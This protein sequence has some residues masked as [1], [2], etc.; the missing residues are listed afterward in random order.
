VFFFFLVGDKKNLF[1]EVYD[2]YQTLRGENRR[3]IIRIE[4]TRRRDQTRR[5]LAD[6]PRTETCDRPIA[7]ARSSISSGPSPSR[8]YDK[9]NQTSVGT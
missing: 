9:K 6:R 7:E 5:E 4:W 3:S 1:S 8:V 2:V